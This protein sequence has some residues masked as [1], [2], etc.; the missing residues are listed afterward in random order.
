[1]E[2][3][4]KPD[5]FRSRSF[6]YRPIEELRLELAGPREQNRIPTFGGATKDIRGHLPGSR[7]GPGIRV[8]RRVSRVQQI[9]LEP[10]EGDDLRTDAGLDRPLA[11]IVQVGLKLEMHEPVTQRTRHRKVDATLR[12]RIAGGDDDPSFRQHVFAELAIK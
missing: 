8:G 11:P 1:M 4:E 3:T 7:S 12:S 5:K 9:R 2:L 6:A 10:Q